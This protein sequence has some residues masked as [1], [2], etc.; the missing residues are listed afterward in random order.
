MTPAFARAKESEV[1]RTWRDFFVGDWSRESIGEVD[2]ESTKKKKTSWTCERAGA[3]IIARGELPEGGTYVAM[4]AWNGYDE[5]LREVARSTNGESWAVEF[6]P[7][8]NKTLCG[9]ATGAL[10]DGRTGK[11]RC[12]ITRIDADSYEAVFELKLNDDSTFRVKDVNTRKSAELGLRFGAPVPLSGVV[13]QG[14][15]WEQSV[16]GDGLSLFFA[17]SREG[18]Q[19][20]DVYVATRE[21]KD[22]PWGNVKNLGPKVNGPSMDGSP[23][24]SADGLALYFNSARN[25]GLGSRDLWMSVRKDPK[26][27]WTDAVNMG[28]GINSASFEGWPTISSDGLELF[29]TSSRKSLN[30]LLVARRAKVTDPWG[31]PVGLG[32]QGATPDISPDGRYLFFANTP[33]WGAEGEGGLDIFVMKRKNRT[34]PFGKPARLGAPINTD[35]DDYSPNVSE[36]GKSLTFY[37]KGKIWRV[38]LT[39]Q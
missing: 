9:E 18:S 35:T 16:T 33:D 23:D 31:K 24:I 28:E 20:F 25:D 29:F 32:V 39:S 22:A 21:A 38:P 37:S 36:D 10:A 12:V 15:T 7:E 17:S 19:D 1:A 30:E 5:S 34:E 11:G 8:N 27:A 4:M 13:N 2:G 3:A 26:A 6:K 14:L